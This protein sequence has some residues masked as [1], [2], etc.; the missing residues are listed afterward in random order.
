L[1]ISGLKGESELRAYNF[2]GME[3]QMEKF[4]AQGSVFVKLRQNCPQIIQIKSANEKIYLKV[5][6]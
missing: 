2:K 6:K 4:N 3:I 5:V 1:H